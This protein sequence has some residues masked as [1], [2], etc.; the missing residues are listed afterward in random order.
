MDIIENDYTAPIVAE[1]IFIYECQLCKNRFNVYMYDLPV[2]L[3]ETSIFNALMKDS[4]LHTYL[5]GCKNNQS[6]YGVARLIGIEK[7]E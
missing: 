7:V 6:V 3:L 4:H 5:H 1:Y 2:N